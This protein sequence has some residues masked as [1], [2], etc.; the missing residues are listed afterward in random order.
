M[1]TTRKFVIL[2]MGILW[3]GC[4]PQEEALAEYQIQPQPFHKVRI[5]DS[6]WRP[7][8]EINRTVSISHNFKQCEATGRISNFSKA[9]GLMEGAHQG[10]PWGDS[11]VYKVMEGAIYSLAIH[12]DPELK[13]YVDD[14]IQDIAAAQEEDGYLYTPRTVNPQ[15]THPYCG[16]TRWSHGYS[17]E[18][19][20]PGH[21]YEAAVAHYQL[22]GEREMLDVAIKN[23]DLLCEVFGPGKKFLSNHPEIELA[24]VKLYQSTGL[25]KYLDLSY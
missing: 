11:D 24:L 15:Q 5:K 2:L 17:H 23:A 4:C 22:T 19:F 18:L 9:A 7:K 25:E 10:L 6:F 3:I 16:P 21:F 8:L 20:N 13:S 12:P 1:K 14:L